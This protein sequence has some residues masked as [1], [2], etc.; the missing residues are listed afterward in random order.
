MEVDNVLQ[1]VSRTY[2]YKKLSLMD[3]FSV[4]VSSLIDALVGPIYKNYKGIKIGE[5]TTVLGIP[6]S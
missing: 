2:E 6:V 1:F 5:S 4:V 3:M